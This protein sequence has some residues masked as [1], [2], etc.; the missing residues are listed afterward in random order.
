[1]RNTSLSSDEEISSSISSMHDCLPYQ[2]FKT[3]ILQKLS[4]MAQLQQFVTKCHKRSTTEE[5][6]D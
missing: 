4:C 1:M 3:K 2:R 6:A 5:F